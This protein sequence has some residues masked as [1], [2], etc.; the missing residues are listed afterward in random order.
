[1]DYLRTSLQKYQNQQT[2]SRGHEGGQCAPKS[3]ERIHIHEAYRESRVR[4]VV[5][6]GHRRL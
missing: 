6:I 2:C 3:F 1:M 4:G 5:G